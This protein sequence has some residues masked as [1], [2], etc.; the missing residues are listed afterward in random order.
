MKAL[1]LVNRL[2]E[3]ASVKRIRPNPVPALVFGEGVTNQAAIDAATKR[4]DDFEDAYN[5]ASCLCSMLILWNE[6]R[7]IRCVDYNKDIDTRI[8]HGE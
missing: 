1:L 8:V 6:Q 4:F 7:V 2:W 5:K 3:P